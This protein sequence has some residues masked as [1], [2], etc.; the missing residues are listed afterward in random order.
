MKRQPKWIAALFSV[1]LALCGMHPP[2][3]ADAPSNTQ[4]ISAKPFYFTETLGGQDLTL[5]LRIQNNGQVSGVYT[6]FVPGNIRN[7]LHYGIKGRF[8]SDT[9]ILTA[10]VF[11][12]PS[13]GAQ[14]VYDFQGAYFPTEQR[15]AVQFLRPGDPTRAP[16]LIFEKVYQY[17]GTSPILTGI[18]IW[19]AGD[20]RDP[21]LSYKGE[22]YITKH[23]GDGKIEG[24]FSGGDPDQ[25]GAIEGA[26][27]MNDS[28]PSKYSIRFR[29]YGFGFV[30]EWNG[31]LSG[32]NLNYS[33]SISGT[34]QQTATGYN[35]RFAAVLEY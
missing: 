18:W 34:I 1:F 32:T 27:Y 23:Y 25:A 20:N 9:N 19:N 21:K 17:S 6:I 35:A 24:V 31:D 26:V 12:P 10:E 33:Q 7:W 4:S 5:V 16:A 14:K 8:N 15:F 13:A 22:F 11:L 28:S 3:K 30:Q 2:G 29:R